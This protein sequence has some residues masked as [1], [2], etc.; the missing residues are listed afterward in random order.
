MLPMHPSSV[1][2][3]PQLYPNALQ[4]AL[5][6]PLNSTSCFDPSNA[7]SVAQLCPDI[8][9]VTQLCLSLLQLHSQ[10]A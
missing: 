1:T 9:S 2:S 3:A 5:P 4:C 6:V 8:L 10:H 7:P